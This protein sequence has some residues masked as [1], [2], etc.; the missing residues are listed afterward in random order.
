MTG[1]TWLERQAAIE[2][3]RAPPVPPAPRVSPHR[4]RR[5]EL[6]GRVSELLALGWPH[7]KIAAAL[8]ISHGSVSDYRR[9]LRSAPCGDH[10]PIIRGMIP[11][12]IASAE[13]AHRIV[14]GLPGEI[15]SAE[16]PS[17]EAA[18]NFVG[19]YI[20]P[21]PAPVDR[22][23]WR[24]PDEPEPYRGPV[25]T[26]APERLHDFGITQIKRVKSGGLLVSLAAV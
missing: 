24:W 22:H 18:E 10:A 6:I 3:R 21:S 15:A 8:G 19:R 23:A 14:D 25:V 20:A 11:V 4:A 9:A 1:S 5:A 17:T 2:R 16:A 7:R 13:A 12:E 26:A